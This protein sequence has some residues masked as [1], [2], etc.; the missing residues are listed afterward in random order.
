MNVDKIHFWDKF[1]G[2]G[3]RE[4]DTLA[5]LKTLL[6]SEQQKSEDYYQYS[7]MKMQDLSR[8]SLS[9]N[10]RLKW[11]I[12]KENIRLYGYD[13]CSNI[14]RMRIERLQEEIREF[15][16]NLTPQSYA[17]IMAILDA[18]EM[19]YN[20]VKVEVQ[21]GKAKERFSEYF[22][23]YIKMVEYIIG[24]KYNGKRK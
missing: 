1:C 15:I 2:I 10:Q 16:N 24:K 11:E 13:N 4:I 17:K 20:W 19:G 5:L 14:I 7:H 3:D 21:S 6:Y 9:E 8:L 22:E 23:S 12:I 18:E